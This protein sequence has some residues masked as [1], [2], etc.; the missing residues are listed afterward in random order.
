MAATI[1]PDSTSLTRPWCSHVTPGLQRDT[2]SGFLSGQKTPRQKSGKAL[3]RAWTQRA[4]FLAQTRWVAGPAC[5]DVSSCQAFPLRDLPGHLAEIGKSATTIYTDVKRIPQTCRHNI[6]EEKL[7]DIVPLVH[8]LRLFKSPAELACLRKA[9][10][11]T[12]RAFN[13]VMSRN[14]D[15]ESVLQAELECAFR[16]GGCERPAY[17]PV[18]AAGEVCWPASTR[19]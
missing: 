1:S 2:E 12:G 9:G 15:E 3:G 4:T 7:R 11:I 16:V 17:V 8:E 13:T 19:V 18:V 5:G 14:Y 6:P 10:A